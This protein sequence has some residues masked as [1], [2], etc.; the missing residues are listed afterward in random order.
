[1]AVAVTWMA[2]ISGTV[3]ARPFVSR[4]RP[5]PAH[6]LAACS[7]SNEMGNA[8]AAG[9]R[10]PLRT[11]CCLSAA[12]LT[13]GALRRGAANPPRWA[14]PRHTPNDPRKSIAAPSGFWAVGC[15]RGRWAARRDDPLEHTPRNGRSCREY[16]LRCSPQG[17]SLLGAQASAA[18]AVLPPRTWQLIT[19]TGTP[20]LERQARGPARALVRDGK[21]QVAGKGASGPWLPR[22]PRTG[23]GGLSRR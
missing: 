14:P 18:P 19:G 6:R 1:M 23:R 5:I 3:V 16:R 7:P 13:W 8:P 9:S 10:P 11:K 21:T 4:R 22:P 2:R 17:N 12:H 15:G 20:L